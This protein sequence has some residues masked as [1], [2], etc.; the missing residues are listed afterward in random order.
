MNSSYYLDRNYLKLSIIPLNS[1]ETIYEEK[2]TY[3]WSAFISDLGGQSGLWLGI[4]ALSIFNL[5]EYLQRK[6]QI[7]RLKRKA[8]AQV[9]SCETESISNKKY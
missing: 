6:S 9:H 3:I 4:S 1:Y 7:I 8:M 2:A 5:I